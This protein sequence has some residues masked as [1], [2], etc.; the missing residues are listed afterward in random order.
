[1]TNAFVP[2]NGC[3]ACCIH[4]LVI[5]TPRDRRTDYV[6]IETVNPL[7]GEPAF[8]LPHKDNGECVYLG[9]R[10]CEIYDSRP[11]MCRAYDCGA[12]F[13]S[14]S[15]QVRRMAL[16]TGVI[17]KERMDIGRRISRQQEGNRS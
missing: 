8:R 10:G 14:M 5:L 13:R 15:R 4:E 17:S 11:E 16:R 1:M 6:T 3:K 7:N 9:P 2:C 12:H